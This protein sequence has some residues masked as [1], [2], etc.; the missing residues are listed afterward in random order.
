MILLSFVVRWYW[1]FIKKFVKY[2]AGELISAETFMILSGKIRWRIVKYNTISQYE[3]RL[4]FKTIL[5]KEVTFSYNLWKRGYFFIQSL[6]K[7][8]LFH[9]I[10]RKYEKRLIFD[11]ILRTEATYSYN[12]TKE[13]VNPFTGYGKRLIFHRILRK[14]T[15]KG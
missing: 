6:K 15:I 8:S 11:K 3:N 12:L 7:R 14:C 9:E 2:E 1:N 5:Q 4:I 10:L 13:Y